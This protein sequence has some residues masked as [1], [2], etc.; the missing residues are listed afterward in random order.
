MCSFIS[1]SRHNVP[2]HEGETCNE[3]DARLAV[4]N[5]DHDKGSKKEVKRITKACPKKNCRLRID[6]NGGCQHMTCKFPDSYV[7]SRSTEGF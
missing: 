1:C 3:F 6:K 4:Q 2:W 5:K 7:Q